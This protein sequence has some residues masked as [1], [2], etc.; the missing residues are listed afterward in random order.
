MA[1]LQAW[2]TRHCRFFRRLLGMAECVMG[3]VLD[4]FICV[5]GYKIYVNA[6]KKNV[7]DG[8]VEGYLAHNPTLN[9]SWMRKG[10]VLVPPNRLLMVVQIPITFSIIKIPG[11]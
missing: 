2:T 8:I 3:H 5:R 11:Q 9:N 4:R 7:G 6:S 1:M 10:T